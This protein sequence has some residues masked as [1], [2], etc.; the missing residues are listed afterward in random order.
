MCVVRMSVYVFSSVCMSLRGI[1]V[2][3]CKCGLK[4]LICTFVWCVCALPPSLRA[5]IV[6]IVCMRLCAG[7]FAT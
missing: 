4:V 3:L 2:V 1:I 5:V 7:S 6:Y